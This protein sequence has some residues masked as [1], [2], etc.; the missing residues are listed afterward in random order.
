MAGKDIFKFKQFEL[1]HK[2]SPFKIGTDGLLLGAWAGVNKQA[3]H[4]LDIGTGCGLIAHMLAQRAENAIVHGIEIN[5]EAFQE[6]MENARRSSWNNRL[7]MYHGGVQYFNPPNQYD[8]IVSNP[9]YFE[10]SWLSANEQLAKTRHTITLS[11]TSLLESA[12]RLLNQNGSFEVILPFTEGQK[13]I[14]L[15][16]TYD[17]HLYRYT[18]VT[19][20]QGKTV[21]RLLLAFSALPQTVEKSS[22][23]VRNLNGG[24]TDEYL[25]LT[26]DFHSFV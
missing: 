17:L 18:A 21:E 16:K 3:E 1:R 22:L 23:C 8:Q 26:K 15:A 20:K 13:F 19:G 24:Y 12:K 5:A 14:S 7:T 6:A 4:I 9:P 25:A 11:H 2:Q 10:N